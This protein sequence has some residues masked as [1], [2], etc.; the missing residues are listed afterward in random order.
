ML[1]DKW[2]LEIKSFDDDRRMFEGIATTGAIDRMDDVVE[3]KGAILR[4]PIP[5]K[6][7]HGKGFM[8]DDQIGEVTSATVTP[9]GIPVK[10]RF[11]KAD[12]PPSLKED[13]DRIWGFIKAGMRGL[14]IGFNP[15]EYEP[16][17]G[18]NGIRFTSW[19]MLELSPVT[20]AANQE[21]AITLIKQMNSQSRAALGL[22][23]KGVPLIGISPGASGTSV[24]RPGAVKLIPR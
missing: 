24:T 12:E 16:I 19:E 9:K 23:R 21:A 7:Q 2:S 5:M 6:W 18:S 20:V 4:L 13:F 11:F 15:I 3:P 8:G 14:S 10:G 17:K 1:V 22:T